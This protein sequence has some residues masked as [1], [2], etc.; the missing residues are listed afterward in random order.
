MNQT[1]LAWSND[2]AAAGLAGVVV[3]A[4]TA[5]PDIEALPRVRLRSAVSEAAEGGQN[6]QEGQVA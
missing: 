2:P 1:L 6:P 4:A 3:G 5:T